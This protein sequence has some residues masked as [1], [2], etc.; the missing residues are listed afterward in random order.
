MFE[1]L[2]PLT[3]QIVSI[4]QNCTRTGINTYRTSA[5]PNVYYLCCKCTQHVQVLVPVYVPYEYRNIG[6]RRVHLLTTKDVQYEYGILCDFKIHRNDGGT[7]K[8]KMLIKSASWPLSF[9]FCHCLC[10]TAR[11]RGSNW[12]NT[13]AAV[14]NHGSV[15]VFPAWQWQMWACGWK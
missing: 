11:T 13:A 6:I 14:Y 7:R 10:V 4:T 9:L 3:C 5:I 1:S 2:L 12:V 8:A 15:P